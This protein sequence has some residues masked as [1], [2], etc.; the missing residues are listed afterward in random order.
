MIEALAHR[1]LL[2]GRWLTA[3]VRDD[4]QPASVADSAIAS[5]IIAVATALGM[6]L[7]FVIRHIIV[8]RTARPESPL[9]PMN[10]VAAALRA[11]SPVVLVILAIPVL[12]PFAARGGSAAASA[13]TWVATVCILALLIR[14]AWG[15]SVIIAAW[16]RQRSAGT[17]AL[18]DDLLVELG[19]QV[20]RTLIVVLGLYA[21]TV[22]V[23]VPEGAQRIVNR[24][25]GLAIIALMT[26]TLIAL[27]RMSDRF[28]RQRFRIDVPDNLMARRVRTQLLVMRRL[29]YLVIGVLAVSLALMQFEPIRRI[30]ASIL[31][32]A[33]LAGVII[34][35]AAQRTLAN[36][37]AGIQI[38]MTQPLRI[39]DA[40][41][42]EGDFGRVEEI[43]LTY[44][45]IGTWDKRR[46]IVPL[47]HLI[48]NPFQNWTRT[49]TNLLGTVMVRCDFRVPVAALR[50]EAQRLIEDH[51]LWDR[52]A[53][54]VQVTDWSEHTVEIRI[55]VSAADSASLFAL[56]CALREALLHWLQTEHPTAL[57]R[58]RVEPSL[59]PASDQT[60][61]DARCSGPLGLTCG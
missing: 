45:V 59:A 56:R 32:S 48:E 15:M 29:A 40:V 42:M 20:A 31:A 17:P 50:A 13:I 7:W 51:S 55:L 9:A 8:R 23:V 14:A 34:G 44:V 2:L 60:L 10:L 12:A 26:W 4:P 46:W 33:G 28:L 52:T 3:L 35:F 47:S 58:I 6:G 30:G 54:A 5:V 39:Q 41:I 27:V 21:I 43:T 49:T 37:L 1:L 24:F 22:L 25:M 11:V 57:A 16:L 61:T 53:F 36:L 19:A 38:A 18:W